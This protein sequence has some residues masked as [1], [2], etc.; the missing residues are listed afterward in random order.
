MYSFTLYLAKRSI[1]FSN[2]VV[3]I[4]Y[5]EIYGGDINVIT[6]YMK[7]GEERIVISDDDCLIERDEKGN[8]NEIDAA[9]KEVV[10]KKEMNVN[11]HYVF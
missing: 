11:K 8:E 4:Y 10:F 1:A 7:E 6:E 3:A 5:Q 2:M 9:Q